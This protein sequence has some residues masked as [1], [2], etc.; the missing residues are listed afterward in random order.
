M[1]V[2]D[3]GYFPHAALHGRVR[4][5]GAAQAIL[6]MCAD[7]GGWCELDGGRHMEAPTSRSSSRRGCRT[8]TTQTL[9]SPG[10]SGGST[11][12]ERMFPISSPPSAC[13]PA[14]RPRHHRSV[15]GLRVGR[16]HLRRHGARRDLGASLTAAA[17][18]AW[19]LL[20]QLAAERDGCSY[21]REPIALVQTYLREHLASPTSVPALAELAGFSPSH[22]PVASAR[23]PAFPSPS[24]SSDSAWPVPASS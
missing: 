21:A 12:R 8:A 11:S 3:A 4:R 6:I 22:S 2:T 1:F 24:T 23:S 16:E 18:T 19:N 17:G 7:G 5:A 10:R 13:P 20:A 15:P 14:P 9:R